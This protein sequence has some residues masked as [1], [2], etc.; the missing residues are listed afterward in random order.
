MKRA[1]FLA[2]GLGTRLA[3]ITLNTPKALVRVHGVRF[4]DR[5]LDA[6]LAAGLNELY[7]VRGY[8]SEQFDQLLSKYPMIHFLEIRII[9]KRITSLP[10]WLP[11]R[12]SPVPIFS[13][14]IC[15]SQ[16]LRLSGSTITPP[17]SWV[18]KSRSA[19]TGAL[20]SETASSSIRNSAVKERISGR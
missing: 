18:S 11:T 20:R 7:V 3:P 13:K 19:M 2:A 6:C 5:L 10:L 16:T 17:T 9:T 14:R 12:Y 15:C 4:I 8:L 1:V